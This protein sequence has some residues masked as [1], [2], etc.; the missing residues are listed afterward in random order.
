M[1]SLVASQLALDA[2]TLDAG[3]FLLGQLGRAELSA[4][5]RNVGSVD[6][7]LGFTASVSARIRAA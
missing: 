3:A 5:A 7:E 4:A 1:R 6:A 2:L